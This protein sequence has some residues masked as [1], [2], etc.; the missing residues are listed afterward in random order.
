MYWYAYGSTFCNNKLLEISPKSIDGKHINFGIFY[1]MK[2]YTAVKINELQ[3]HT[4]MNLRNIILSEK[5]PE[6]SYCMIPYL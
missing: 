5:F 6:D 4:W 2:Y 3:F 1:S